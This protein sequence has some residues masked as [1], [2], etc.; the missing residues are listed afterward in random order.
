MERTAKLE[1]SVDNWLAGNVG[2]DAERMTRA[3]LLISIGDKVATL[4][5]DEEAKSV[6]NRIR[7][8][9]YHL[10]YWLAFG[11]WRLNFEPSAGSDKSLDW[12]MSHEMPAIGHGCV[13]PAISFVPDG[14]RV[15]IFVRQTEAA[16]TEPIRYIEEFVES[17]SAKAFEVGI[18]SFIELVIKRLNAVGL[19]DTELHHLW[20]DVSDECQNQDDFAYRSLEAALGYDPDDAPTEV[21]AQLRGL[22]ALAGLGAIK[23]I[24]SACGG[25]DPSAALDRIIDFSTRPGVKATV[26]VGQP[27]KGR[28]EVREY[29]ELL[30]WQRG[31]ML[32]EAA[33]SAWLAGKGRVTDDD[34]SALLTISP[35]IL[36]HQADVSNDL[37]LGLA[38]RDSQYEAQVKLLFRKRNRPARRFEAARFL[39]STI[40]P[41]L[42]DAWLPST[43]AKTAVQKTQR[44]FAAEFLC[45]IDQLRD[46]LGVGK[47]SEDK[48]ED[49]AS[50]FGVSP[51]AVVSHLKNHGDIPYDDPLDSVLG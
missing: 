27:L 12:R 24:A 50:F 28:N 42:T 18:R 7:V 25:D 26:Q 31:K 44:A 3:N 11:W 36:Q 47:I 10:A 15:H 40:T 48:V 22:R 6:R 14:E 46:Y 43:D 38:V 29:E 13:W 33:R 17:V 1:F 49:A 9:A 45:P 39:G 32:A 2:Q 5:Y 20:R 8:P 30:P 41:N 16:P 4:V 19:R 37:P 34:L 23:E 51:M 21:I 35:D